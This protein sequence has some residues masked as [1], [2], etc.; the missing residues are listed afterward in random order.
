MNIKI[1][2]DDWCSDCLVIKKL[3]DDYNIPYEYI[4]ISKRIIKYIKSIK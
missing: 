4:M 3:L 1:Y 2:G